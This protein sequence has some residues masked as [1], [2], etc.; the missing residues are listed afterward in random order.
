MMAPFT[1][2]RDQE[3]DMGSGVPDDFLEESKVGETAEGSQ[4]IGS[5]LDGKRSYQW[6]WQISQ[7]KV[8]VLH[9]KNLKVLFHSKRYWKG[10]IPLANVWLL[11]G[12]VGQ[13]KWWACLNNLE[14]VISVL[15]I[16]HQ[17]KHSHHPKLLTS[18]K[19]MWLKSDIDKDQCCFVWTEHVQWICPEKLNAPGIFWIPVADQL[20][21]ATEFFIQWPGSDRWTC[22]VFGRCHQQGE[23]VTECVFLKLQEILKRV[24]EDRR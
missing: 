24:G 21:S 10:G 4:K 23:C 1:Y 16:A 18:E 11:E 14:I 20:R 19:A 12:T 15:S 6:H 3:D 5:Q 2:P 8:F 17:E 13:Q 22:G 7:N 9:W